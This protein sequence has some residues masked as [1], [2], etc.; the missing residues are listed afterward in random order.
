VAGTGFYLD[1]LQGKIQ[2]LDIQPNLQLRH[3]LATFSVQQ[4][5]QQLSQLN[6]QQ[7]ASLNPSDRH[8]PARLIRA[9]EVASSPAKSGQ[10]IQLSVPAISKLNLL[11]LTMPRPPLLAKVDARIDQM[12]EQGL[13]E[14]VQQLLQQYS[15]SAQALSSIGYAEIAAYLNHQCSLSQAI[16]RS[17]IRTHQ[18]I[19]RQYTWFNKQSVNWIDITQSD[20]QN[21][22]QRLAEHI[23]Q[24]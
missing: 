6:P 8:N 9:I 18:Y 10:T 23:L 16:H 2:T 20:W 24:P 1:A 14:E 22:A 7:A 3:T 11:G 21:Q 19:K 5:L 4:L 12:I 15:S 13:V 17:K